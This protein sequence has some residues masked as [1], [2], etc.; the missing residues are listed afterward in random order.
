[1]NNHQKQEKEKVTLKLKKNNDEKREICCSLDSVLVKHIF[2]FLNP[3]LCSL[4]FVQYCVSSLYEKPED[5]DDPQDT[6][7][8]LHMEVVEKIIEVRE[9]LTYETVYL[10]KKHNQDKLF[11]S[12]LVWNEQMT[13]DQWNFW[14]EKKMISFEKSGYVLMKYELIYSNESMH[15]PKPLVHETYTQKDVLIQPMKLILH[16][17]NALLPRSSFFRLKI[18]ENHYDH[19]FKYFI[20][21]YEMN[22]E[23][24][25]FLSEIFQKKEEELKQSLTY[26]DKYNL[27]NEINEKIKESN[28]NTRCESSPL[29]YVH[30]CL[31]NRTM[32]IHFLRSWIENIENESFCMSKEFLYELELYEQIV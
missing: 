23:K 17:M 1:M 28:D 4:Y 25:I 32:S 20:H 21:I 16:K 22:D 29:S 9:E 8:I 27:R 30:S 6:S 5:P 11:H 26:V 10:N 31:Q 14:K 3:E 15:D 2:S 12:M 19:Y 7:T 13:C 24:I 18:I